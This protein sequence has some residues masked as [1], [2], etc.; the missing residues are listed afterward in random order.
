ML[1]DEWWYNHGPLAGVIY[2]QLGSLAVL[3]NSMRLLWFERSFQAQFAA[4]T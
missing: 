1:T 2:H 4:S 3:L